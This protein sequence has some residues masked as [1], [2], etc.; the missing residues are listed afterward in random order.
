MRAFLRKL[1]LSGEAIQGKGLLLWEGNKGV[2][3]ILNGLVTRGTVCD[4]I[5]K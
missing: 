5:Y 4:T 1:E 3:G 2:V